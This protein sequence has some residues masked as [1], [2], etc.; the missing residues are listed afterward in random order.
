MIEREAK[1]LFNSCSC[2]NID[3]GTDIYEELNTRV[4]CQNEFC[5]ELDRNGDIIY[6][7]IPNSGY[8]TLLEVPPQRT[9]GYEYGQLGQK[10]SCGLKITI[11]GIQNNEYCTDCESLNKIHESLQLD[12]Y[13][14]AS[15]LPNTY[16][17][18]SV[19]ETVP[20]WPIFLSNTNTETLPCNLRMGRAFI[21]F[22]DRT[23]TKSSSGIYP[24]FMF[25]ELL[26]HRFIDSSASYET[27]LTLALQAKEQ[28]GEVFVDENG[29]IR[30]STFNGNEFSPFSLTNI[31]NSGLYCEYSSI[32]I[33]VERNTDVELTN[34]ID[35]TT[36]PSR[37]TFI[38]D[39]YPSWIEVEISGIVDKNCKECENLN[40]KHYLQGSYNQYTSQYA[41]R[42][43]SIP[44]FTAVGLICPT[45]CHT[46]VDRMILNLDNVGDTS[47]VNFDI[48]YYKANASTN[49]AGGAIQR[50]LLNEAIANTVLSSSLDAT[51]FEV[52]FTLNS[53]IL[54][55]F[56]DISNATIK[57]R[58]TDF[59]TVQEPALQP[60]SMLCGSG[61]EFMSVDITEQ[62]TN[63]P[64][65]TIDMF[66][67][68]YNGSSAFTYNETLSLGFDTYELDIF[69]TPNSDKTG[70]LRLQIFGNI[71]GGF[72]PD[73]TY[74]GNY[75]FIIPLS[76][77]RT[78]CTYSSET[79][80]QDRTGT[81]PSGSQTE[82]NNILIERV[83]T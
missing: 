63:F 22:E 75:N 48:H 39:I 32:S 79:F 29:V 74:L 20:Y 10:V 38:N 33:L 1:L 81:F 45:G 44:D 35:S 54:S 65:N 8:D 82:L 69:V 11:A 24:I 37:D 4:F 60:R 59:T 2:F 72:G 52:E 47:T 19:Q 18:S 66:L 31:V 25:F 14:V 71:D 28:I 17:S 40:R 41:Y 56:C 62:I 58:N 7:Q 42:E 34:I 70:L 9:T 15:N 73:T 23:F 21:G 67:L 55:D 46:E 57:I 68:S 51:N 49:P 80:F 61:T 30:N 64:I 77:D 16:P 12:R 26:E 43:E 78:N 53:G 5:A 50:L 6:R 76:E 36:D 3:I 83:I 13:V 27:N